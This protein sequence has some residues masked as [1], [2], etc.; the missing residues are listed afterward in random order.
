LWAPLSQTASLSVPPQ[1][2]AI[3]AP[4]ILRSRLGG[5]LDV[6]VVRHVRHADGRGHNHTNNMALSLD[7]ALYTLLGELWQTSVAHPI[8]QS[9]ETYT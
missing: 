9:A 4:S 6:H 7:L 1:L 3:S 2:G 8:F 5:E